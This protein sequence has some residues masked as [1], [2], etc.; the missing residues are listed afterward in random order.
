M[1]GNPDPEDSFGFSSLPR[2][3]VKITKGYWLGKIEVTQNQWNELMD[4][5][6]SSFKNKDCPVDKISWHDCCA[7]IAF[8]NFRENVE[9]YRLPSEAEWEYSCRGGT[10][11][12]HYGEFDGIPSDLF[13][14]KKLIK[15]G[16]SSPNPWGLYDM[17]GSVNEW[18]LDIED[19][20]YYKRSPLRDP[21]GPSGKGL[22][23]SFILTNRAVRGIPRSGS[24]T[25]HPAPGARRRSAN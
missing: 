20:G 23:Q 12:Y 13:D 17:L 3:K 2:H 4:H 19:S 5:N 14:K 10:K 21:V 8:L 15:T 11:P 24:T 16:Q 6:P 1:M 7:F 18:C 25:R 9:K 22:Y